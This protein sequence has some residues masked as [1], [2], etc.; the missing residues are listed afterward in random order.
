MALNPLTYGLPP[1]GLGVYGRARI[2]AGPWSWVAVIGHSAAY[3]S[4]AAEVRSLGLPLWL[5]AFPSHSGPV[6]WRD[7]LDL[8]V[9]RARE[10]GAVGIIVD[11]ET[12]WRELPRDR[13]IAEMRAYGAALA[14][15]ARSG[16]RVGATSHAFVP[17]IET[18]VDAAGDGVWW[19]PQIYSQ[20]DGPGH[21]AA[22]FQRWYDV[23]AGAGMRRIPSIAGWVPDREPS[24]GTPAGFAAYLAAL[25][26]ASGAIVFPGGSTV[27]GHMLAALQGYHP[28]GSVLGTA[29]LEA[30]AIVS[31]L[32]FLATLGGV[33]LIVGAVAFYYA[34]G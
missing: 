27:P 23:F 9:R 19:S 14:D 7:G 6:T 2:P 1:S 22:A 24:L 25:P 29:A 31:R 13:R 20:S 16:L 28:G 8:L 18:L 21:D 11:P 32:A 15:I 3:A 34:R 26:K 17:D 10:T 5:W 33:L 12:G 4:Q 30:G